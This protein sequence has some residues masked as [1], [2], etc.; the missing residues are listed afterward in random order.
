MN[1]PALATT[2]AAPPAPVSARPRFADAPRRA[3]IDRLFTAI[4]GGAAALIGVVLLVVA[5]CMVAL[6][7]PALR[8]LG[9][10]FVS[11]RTWRPDTGEL[12]ALPFLYG[13]AVTSAVALLLAVPVALGVALFLTDLGPL[14][15]RRPVSAIVELLAAV[16][17][18]VYGL[19]AAIVLAPL[20]REHVEPALAATAGVVPLFRGPQVGVGLLC[21]AAV[22]AVMIMPTIAS[23]SREVLRAVPSELREG[24]LALG[25][26]PWDVARLIVLPHARSGVLGAVLL[27]FGRAVGETMAVAMVVGSR[28]EITGSLF[29]PG[30]T[31]AS[32]LAN[33]FAQA[34]TRLHVAAL[35]E[36]GLLL[37]AITLAFNVAAR[38]LVTRV[39]P[40]AR[41]LA[42]VMPAAEETP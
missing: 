16:P 5:A 28:A 32:V 42:P 25:A 26:T 8:E 38:L 33:E 10:G 18:V 15:L 4:G 3:T 37:F 30:Y 40:G 9:L 36:I 14:V 20:M 23:V 2:E 12:G 27:G 1:E 17:G 39:R 6:A 21:A 19:W 34:G 31:M 11:G 41:P 29:S 35:A 24:A 7:W 22:L 13:T